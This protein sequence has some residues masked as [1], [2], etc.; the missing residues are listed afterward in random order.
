[1]F[2][3][4]K[5]AGPFFL[6]VTLCLGIMVLGL[7]L[8]W[9]TRRQKAGKIVLT[10]GVVLFGSL[11]YGSLSNL[12]LTPLEGKYSP[13]LDPRGLK[14]IKW[15]VVLGGGHSSDPLLPVT[16]QLAEPALFRLVEGIRLHK[17]LPES[18]LIL[19]G[20]SGFDPVPDAKIMLDAALFLGVDRQDVVL[21]QASKDT[22]D[23]ARLIKDLVKDD[24]FIL[25]TSASHMPR[26]MALFEAQGMRPIP[27]PS[28]HLV[29]ERQGGMSPGMFFPSALGLAKAERAVYEY[30]GFM[31]SKI[32]GEI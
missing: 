6:P 29:K 11:S 15:V 32:T 18:R 13:V 7:I 22:K 19:S 9:F 3:L 20:G 2:L 26:S 4:K 27:A 14:G 1:M 25:V 16:S 17:L 28:D 12:L 23:E 8:L 5:V 24:R 31:W 30:L 10:I 21:E